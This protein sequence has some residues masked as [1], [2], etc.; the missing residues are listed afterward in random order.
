MRYSLLLAAVPVSSA[1]FAAETQL[2]IQA[3]RPGK[4]IS[5]NLVGVFFEDLN[6]AADGGLYAELIQNR[7]FEYSPT[8]QPEWTPLSFW[9][10]VKRGDGDGSLRVQST[11]PVHESNPHYTILTVAKPGEGVGIA[12]G[13]FD[14]IPLKAG[15]N[16]TA[17][18]WAYQAF[19]NDMWSGNNKID[20]RPMPVTL[21]L[22][23]KSGDVL[24]EAKVN[25]A[26]RQWQRLSAKLTPNRAAD[27]ARF[28]LLAHAK[29]G[30]AIDM[31]SLFPEKT[32]LKRDNGLRAD[33][34]Q[35]LADLK[36]K[37]MRFPGGCLVHGQGV[38]RYYNWKDS[39]GPVE[40]RKGQRN[41]W[42]YHQTLGL[43]YFE[44]FQFCEDI[45]AAP[46][47]VVSAG[48]CCQHAGDSPNMGQEGLPMEEMPAYVQD[49]LDLIEWA[50]GPATSK[51]GSKR[52]AAG[53]PEPFGLEYLGVGN[54]DEI[55]PAFK[56][57]FAMIF[58]AI[59]AKHPKITV[60][61]TVG[62][63]ADGKD[64]DNG[65]AF[66]RELK[67]PMVDEHYYVP[68]QWF[69]DNLGRYDKY[70]RT[71]RK[72]YVG[73]YAAHDRN[74]RNTL[75]SAIAEAAG[76]TS[77]ERNGDVVSFASYA[78]LLARRNHTQWHPDLI[79][80]TGKDVILS[81]NYYVQQLFGHNSGDI[82]L[83]AKLSAAGSPSTLAY[84]AVRDSKSG[85]VIVK[86]VNGANA[87]APLTVQLEG[88]PPATS[89]ETT[90]TVL[91]GPNPDA[92]NEDGRPPVVRAE[93]SQLPLKPTFDCEVPANSVTVF[94]F[95]QAATASR[96]EESTKADNPARNPIIWAD[97][98]DLAI[99]RVNDTY[100]MSSTTMHLSPGL[101]IMKS[102]DLVNW[103]IVGY[104]YDTLGD[105][106]ALTL[107]NGKN[108]YGAG[109]WASS[110]RYHDGTFYVTTFS[111]TTGKT[112]VYRTKDIENGP[113]TASSFRPSLHDH[114]LFFDDDGRVY[115]IYGNNNLRLVELT[116]DLSGIKPGGVDQVIVQ[117]AS[118]VAGPNVGLPAE[119]S[120]MRKINGKYYL[121]NITW[122][123]GGMRT[124]LIFRADKLTGPYEG[125]VALADAG[126]A[127]GGL[128]DTP[129][130]DWYALLFQDHGA[131]GRIP[132][133]VPLKWQDGWPVM[134]VDGKVPQTLTIPA[135]PGGLGNLVAS[136]EFD[137]SA[138]QP[139]LPLAW[140]W[141]HNPDN[142]R[143]SLTARPG[144]L[145]LTTGRVDADFLKARNSLT[146]RTF[147]PAC[148]ATVALDVS[149]MKD[150]DVA[151]LAALQ[152]KFGFV[153]VKASGE[154]KALVMVSAQS[155]VPA[156]VESVPLT[157]ETVFLKI[158]CDFKDRADKARFF[159]SLDGNAWTA[160]GKPLQ[161][162]YTLPHFMGY[163]FALFNYATRTA[164]GFVDFDYFRVS[165]TIT[166]A[167]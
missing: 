37:F 137:R 145:R 146:Q 116:A 147:G 21:R 26:G 73:E 75:R 13:G 96:P 91:T 120:Q 107:N 53:H 49:I 1:L 114:S 28:V 85:D 61:G 98:P 166:R 51:W 46:L 126:V 16:Y 156:E 45:G 117:D 86:I 74:R 92:V 119:G 133:L 77:F 36:P 19:M 66:A 65:W 151:G 72:V 47:P 67:V 14:G 90:K 150:G 109:S 25:V 148:S 131:V 18:F 143:W 93:T 142:E 8:E 33:L 136:D 5:P 94:R 158:E 60:I 24:A 11:R 56:E 162:A 153:G 100:Y 30:L 81:A 121:S 130:G 95:R 139:P 127:Q 163:R 27:D 164:G 165:G 83:D 82:C 87:P 113:W 31:I 57:R 129:A 44:Y 10:V 55:T 54:E 134:G 68:P 132:Y 118:R 101:P 138:G 140:Q 39:I 40:Q 128:I 32:F 29:G 155:D 152:K 23:S 42:G 22:E 59:K 48:V 159:Y 6:Y 123:R 7:S 106:D 80:F 161:M 38:H 125:K 62:P 104:A 99:I 154:A 108:A 50:N 122:P 88:L 115:M 105:N 41:L 20:G 76:L 70:D 167:D 112:H 12:N 2:I 124:Q 69:W 71:N 64:Y 135:G 79:Y 102:K 9:D 103:Q 110:L 144:F 141:N 52:A 149:H 35:A 15:E 111:S 34:A 58:E 89:F 3:D 157:K 4:A 17:S 63:F 43:G 84:S 97:V 160:I 78:P